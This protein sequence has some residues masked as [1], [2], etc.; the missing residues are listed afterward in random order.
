[1]KTPGYCWYNNDATTY[2]NIYGALYNWYAVK[3]GK[4]CPAGWHVP[5]YTEW[6][7]LTDYFGNN[8]NAYYKLRETGTIHW[9][10]PDK[11]VTNESGFTALSGGIIYD[12]G[13]WSLS[14]GGWR[15][16]EFYSGR[17]VPCCHAVDKEW[18]ICFR[19]QR[20]YE[21]EFI[22]SLH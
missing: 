7:I 14:Q 17:N 15:M 10:S 16:V 22:S 4:L 11:E 9:I 21:N 18:R 1:M 5:T 20:K 3:T 6:T 12:D 19:R 13:S 8:Q 2:K